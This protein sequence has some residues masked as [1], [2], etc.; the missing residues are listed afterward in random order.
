M[1]AA[2]QLALDINQVR[3]TG[4]VMVR[5]DRLWKPISRVVSFDRGWLGLL[6]SGRKLF[7]TVAEVGHDVAARRYLE[8][9]DFYGEVLATDLLDRRGPV[10][11]KNGIALPLIARD[12]RRLGLL[13][14]RAGGRAEWGDPARAALEQVAPVLADL[15]DPMTTIAGLTVLAP[16]ACAAA[17]VDREGRTGPVPGLP[18]HPALRDRSALVRVAQDVL[19]NR[20]MPAVFLSPSGD[21]YLQITAIA[22]PRQ[23]PRSL[24]ALVLVSRPDNLCG[25]TRRELE[26]LGFLIEGSSNPHI[27]AELFITERT[28]AAH[29]DHIR[30]KLRAGSRTVAAVQA[31]R[32][33]LYIPP[34]LAA[35]ADSRAWR[36]A[37]P[38]GRARPDPHPDPMR[39]KIAGEVARGC[40]PRC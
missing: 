26:V 4:G 20:R 8:S 10:D 36:P 12:G 27:A 38:S 5:L 6:D 2:T 35:L 31:L 25:L 11:L 3:A 21:D 32:Q 40:G 17:V 37:G 1:A 23:P 33:G 9:D 28:V 19:L 29:L 24:A 30:A 13:I 18:A 34:E 16:G 39:P 7:F 22:T 14:L 15:V